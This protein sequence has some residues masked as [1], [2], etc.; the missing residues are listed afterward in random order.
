ML[1]K[2]HLTKNLAPRLTPSVSNRLLNSFLIN[3]ASA[4]D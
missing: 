4:H 1:S 3:I 2:V